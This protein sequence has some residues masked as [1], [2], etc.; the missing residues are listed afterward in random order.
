MTWRIDDQKADLM[1]VLLASE[2]LVLGNY[3]ALRMSLKKGFLPVAMFHA[4]CTMRL[5]LTVRR[6]L[7]S[8][9]PSFFG[10]QISIQ[11]LK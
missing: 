9:P 7:M 2:K 1:G 6:S 3:L 4:A 10:L 8:N 11:D 5:L